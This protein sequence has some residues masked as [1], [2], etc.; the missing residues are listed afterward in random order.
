MSD[1]TGTVPVEVPADA[2]ATVEA[3]ADSAQQASQ[4]A[5]DVEPAASATEAVTPVTEAAP[6]IEAPAVEAPAVEPASSAQAVADATAAGDA[7]AGVQDAAATGG[8]ATPGSGSP[9]ATDAV[10][11]VQ[12]A[13]S[14]TTQGVVDDVVSGAAPANESLAAATS[15][16]DTISEQVATAGGG[17]GG[18]LPPADPLTG[19]LEPLPDVLSGQADALT[20]TGALPNLLSGP[21][22]SVAA[23]VEEGVLAAESLTGPVGSVP[24]VLSGSADALM[25]GGPVPDVLSGTLD[26]VADVLSGPADALTGD[27]PVPDVLSG[28]LDPVAAGVEEGTLAAESVPGGVASLPDGLLAEGTLP[29]GLAPEAGPGAIDPLAGAD[30]G[31]GLAELAPVSEGEGFPF[32]VLPAL[33]P[34]PEEALILSAG[35]ATLAGLSM[36]ARASGTSILTTRFLLA[37]VP[38]IPVRC[39]VAAAVN[40]PAT[41]AAGAAGAVADGAVRG[42]RTSGGTLAQ[43]AAGTLAAVGGELRDGFVYGADRGR[44]RLGDEPAGDTPLWML[45]MLLGTLYFALMSA[46]IWVAKRRRWHLLT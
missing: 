5:V 38:P 31:G 39:L 36:V 3:T 34:G 6:A 10:G 2:E 4:A 35:L 11:S 13:V 21:V 12:D 43:A 9:V 16:T 46:C 41:L 45:A 22:D 30:P 29:P 15:T 24:D 40:R 32:E 19:G 17:G 44:G 20:T 28:L 33:T 7:T 37:G 8:A 14:S 18:G 27:R 25:G 1:Q 26:P 42:I 23:G